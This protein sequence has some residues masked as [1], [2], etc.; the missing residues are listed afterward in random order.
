MEFKERKY[1][2]TDVTTVFGLQA[3]YCKDFNPKVSYRKT[4]ATE[5]L[6]KSKR[7]HCII[8]GKAYR[9]VQDM[10]EQK[11]TKKELQRAVRYLWVCIEAYKHKLDY[12]RAHADFGI[13]ELSDKYSNNYMVV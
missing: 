7:G 3:E 10:Q 11:A 8:V 2:V 6:I 1:G 13:R 5:K 4:K 9:L 12:S